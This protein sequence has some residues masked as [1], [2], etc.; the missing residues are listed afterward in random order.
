MQ[1]ELQPLTPTQGTYWQVRLNEHFVTFRNE[2][3]A[4]HFVD[5]LEAR[6]AAPHDL[7][8]EADTTRG[9]RNV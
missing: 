1:I 3:E 6:L 7:P 8:A 5:R 9:E 2:R 4:R